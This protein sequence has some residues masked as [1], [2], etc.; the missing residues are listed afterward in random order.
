MRLV[1]GADSV[2]FQRQ[3]S[4]SSRSRLDFG[5]ESDGVRAE[6]VGALD[7]ILVGARKIVGIDSEMIVIGR[8]SER[9]VSRVTPRLDPFLVVDLQ[10]DVNRVGF[11]VTDVGAAGV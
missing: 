1:E 2:L 8:P 10:D 3:M 11:H 5:V 7:A 9:A 6:N 4:L